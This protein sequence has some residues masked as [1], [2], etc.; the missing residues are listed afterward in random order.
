MMMGC[1]PKAHRMAA[2]RLLFQKVK[3]TVTVNQ[4]M[5]QKIRTR[6]VRKLKVT[7]TAEVVVL[8]RAAAPRFVLPQ[9]TGQR[10]VLDWVVDK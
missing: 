9:M 7:T 1:R 6:C 3:L 5:N 10:M 2:P 4:K 8:A